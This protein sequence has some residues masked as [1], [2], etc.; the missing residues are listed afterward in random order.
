MARRSKHVKKSV[1]HPGGGLGYIA[2]KPAGDVVRNAFNE[3]KV[4]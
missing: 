4:K 2:D 1:S 3:R